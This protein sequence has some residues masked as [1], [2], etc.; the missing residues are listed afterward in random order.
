MIRWNTHTSLHRYLRR[1]AVVTIGTAGQVVDTIEQR[2][3]FINDE[4]KKKNRLLELLASN[5]EPPIIVFVN[6]KKGCDVLSK[7]LE[8]LGVSKLVFIANSFFET[9]FNFLRVVQSYDTPWW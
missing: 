3:E 9:D 7:A 4:N 1:P 8:K 6:Q 2:A 5:H